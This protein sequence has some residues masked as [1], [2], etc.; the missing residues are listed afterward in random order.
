MDISKNQWRS[1][2]GKTSRINALVKRLQFTPKKDR[3]T[4]AIENF[5]RAWLLIL[6]LPLFCL[7]Q[8]GNSR[9]LVVKELIFYHS[10][11]RIEFFLLLLP[12]ITESMSC[13]LPLFTFSKLRQ[14]TGQSIAFL[15][16][17]SQRGRDLATSGRNKKIFIW[18]NLSLIY[19]RKPASL[20][21]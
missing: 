11:G 5:T 13:W 10:I 4:K 14:Q 12:D 8:G 2:G 18:A 1:T 21:S 7:R 15:N 16:W 17:D 3:C 6:D 20:A 9:R 19:H